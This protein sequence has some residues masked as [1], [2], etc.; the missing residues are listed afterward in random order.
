MAILSVLPSS[1]RS[2]QGRRCS[3]RFSITL[4]AGCLLVLFLF[5]TAAAF[6]GCSTSPPYYSK[7]RSPTSALRL[8]SEQDVLDAVERAEESWAKALAAREEAKVLSDK[9][10][11]ASTSAAEES[12]EVSLAPKDLSAKGGIS[13][14]ADVLQAALD[15]GDL[16]AE[17]KRGS[18]EADRLEA[19]ADRTLALSEEKLEQHLADF[20]DSTLHE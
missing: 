20:P 18:D 4:N 12:E 8:V 16:L 1:V 10:E 14:V 5:S 13:R 9:A 15:A 6:T 7:A 19:M 3:F 11:E 17:A 2:A